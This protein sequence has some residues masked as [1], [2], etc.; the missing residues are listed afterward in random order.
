MADRSDRDLLDLDEPEDGVTALFKVDP[1]GITGQRAAKKD[2]P[3]DDD[4]IRK[5]L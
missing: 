2:D 5:D 1:E 3:A 4:L